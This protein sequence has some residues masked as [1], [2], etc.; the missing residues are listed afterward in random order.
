MRA[1]MGRRFKRSAGNWQLYRKLPN[2]A[3]V[4]VRYDG[5]DSERIAGV[6]EAAL[7]ALKTAHAT[8]Q[9]YVLF[10][11]GTS[12]FSHGATSARS[13]VRGLMRSVEATPFIVRSECIQHDDFF[14]ARI[15]RA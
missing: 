14:V 5:H 1:S 8:R 4:D 2:A 7:D 6:R 13:Q 10:R 9:D 12:A 15:R 11:H 3:E